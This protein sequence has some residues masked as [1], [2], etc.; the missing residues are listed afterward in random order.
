MATKDQLISDVILRVSGGKPSD[1]LELERSQVGFW[2]S[3]ARDFVLKKYLDSKIS[4]GE[5]IDPSYV[6]K[7]TAKELFSEADFGSDDEQLRLFVN[8]DHEP[9][10]LIDDSGIVRVITNE[11]RRVDK[12]DLENVDMI[13][14][15]EF[16]KPSVENLVFYRQGK[17]LIILGVPTEMQDLIY[18][19][20][21]YVPKEDLECLADTDEVNISADLLVSVLEVAEDIGR[22]QVFGPQDLEND[23]NQGLENAQ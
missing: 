12:T 2:I 1:D 7:L 13:V 17:K 14:E 23:G 3:L 4:N 19:T 16:C 10:D 5:T 6:K 11:G 18:I 22:R 8:L 9:L 15:M 21:W 20:V